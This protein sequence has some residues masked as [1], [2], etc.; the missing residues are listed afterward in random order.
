MVKK[1]K[2][3]CAAKQLALYENGWRVERVEGSTL[4]V[5]SPSDRV[6]GGAVCV[7]LQQN[8]SRQG[9]R[10][11]GALTCSARV[12]T[13]KIPFLPKTPPPAQ[14]LPDPTVSFISSQGSVW[15][16]KPPLMFWFVGR[17]S[18]ACRWQLKDSHLLSLTLCQRSWE[19]LSLLQEVQGIVF[20]H[21]VSKDFRT[22]IQQDD[23]K[24]KIKMLGIS[25]VSVMN[26]LRH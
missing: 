25:D 2:N 18:E 20:L 16:A 9:L 17:C 1:N 23:E 5:L 4:L 21:R 13:S 8:K 12:L 24:Q 19:W 3:C 22:L 10:D 6:T 26:V 11:G 15:S 7:W 14:L